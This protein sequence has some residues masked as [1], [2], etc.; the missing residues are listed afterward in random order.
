MIFTIS[1]LVL[2]SD[3]YRKKCTIKGNEPTQY[4]TL[5]CQILISQ[6][7]AAAVVLLSAIIFSMIYIRLTLI[8]VKQAHGTYNL[9]NAIHWTH[10]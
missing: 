2:H 7:A 9:S 3:L 8:A 5:S 4:W 6:M 1:E 10:C